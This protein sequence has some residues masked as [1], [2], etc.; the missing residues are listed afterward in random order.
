MT[1][2]TF[3]AK[4][5]NFTLSFRETAGVRA[6]AKRHE[7]ASKSS[8]FTLIETMLAVLIMALLASAAALSFAAPLRTARA[9]EALDQLTAAD[10]AA[11]K[12]SRESGRAVRLSFD[13]ASGVIDRHF[14]QQLELREVLPSSIRMQD[15]FVNLRI[16]RDTRAEVVFSAAGLS[17]TYAIHVVG[18]RVDRWIVFAGLS[19]ETSVMTDE[20]TV[21]SAIDNSAAPARHNLD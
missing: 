16:Y 8:A 19:G 20:E 6:V 17:P 14:G 7:L 12:L 21:R 18:R 3:L 11:R 5:S 1:T 15:I 10:S 13:P 9:R 4:R 2:A